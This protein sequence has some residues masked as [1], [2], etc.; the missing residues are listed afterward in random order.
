MKYCGSEDKAQAVC[1][2]ENGRGEEPEVDHNSSRL[3]R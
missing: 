1:V 3:I 2:T